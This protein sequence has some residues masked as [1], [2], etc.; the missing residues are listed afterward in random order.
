MPGG[1]PRCSPGPLRIVIFIY[2]KRNPTGQLG[3]YC[4]LT[5]AIRAIS[6]KGQRLANHLPMVAS[7]PRVAS[8]LRVHQ[9]RS[10]PCS[11]CCGQDTKPVRPRQWRIPRVRRRQKFASGTWHAWLYQ[12]CPLARVVWRARWSHAGVRL[13]RLLRLARAEV[14]GHSAFR[15]ALSVYC[16]VAVQ[17]KTTVLPWASPRLP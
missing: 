9:R 7:A 13:Q 1:S 5:Q 11:A 12:S 8:P 4:K 14:G 3:S 6:C 10:P 15:T 16:Y 17:W 2:L